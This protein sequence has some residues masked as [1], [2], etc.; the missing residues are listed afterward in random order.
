MKR[1]RTCTCPPE[2]PGLYVERTFTDHQISPSDALRT[3]YTIERDMPDG[4]RCLQCG[5]SDHDPRTLLGTRYTEE[6]A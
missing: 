1:L 5:A 4:F 3:G 2:Q 6:T